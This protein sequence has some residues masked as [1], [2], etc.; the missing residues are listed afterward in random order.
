MGQVDTSKMGTQWTGV[1]T[2]YALL[3]KANGLALCL[4]VLI[5]ARTKSPVALVTA[6][7]SSI[8]LLTSAVYGV[9]RE[10][11]FDLFVLTFGAW[12]MT[13]GRRPSPVLV[14]SGLLVGTVVL[15]SAANLREYVGSGKGSLVSALADRDTYAR[16]DYT[17]LKQRN[18]S[19]LGLAQHDHWYITM[20]KEWELGAEYWNSLAHQYVPAFLVGR[21]FKNGLMIK[22]LT[23]RLE[24]GEEKGLYSFGSTRTGFSDSYRSFGF[25]GAMVFCVIGAFFGLLFSHAIKGSLQDEYLYLVLLS[26]G[27]KSI[28]HSTSEFFAS[29]PFVMLI[30]LLVFRF[31]RVVGP[32]HE[33]ESRK[34]TP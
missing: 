5:Y 23:R 6:I 3:A 25:L 15:N 30:S 34:A 19:E 9:R 1:I 26:E 13:R 24:T 8:P 10:Q 11:L 31:S 32:I 33:V 12:H 29:L 18:T 7:V 22:T 21:E 27:L 17:D 4:A 2:M 28:T 14:F 20:G 16:F